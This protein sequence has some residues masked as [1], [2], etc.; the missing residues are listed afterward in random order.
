MNRIILALAIS[1]I[2]CTAT[3]QNFIDKI[4]SNVSM[5]IKYAGENFSRN[6]PLK[7]MDS[8]SFVKENLSKAFKIDSLT[9]LRDLGIDFE[10]DTYQFVSM[11]DSSMSFV[12]LFHLNNLPVFLKLVDANYHAE[13]KPEKMNGYE[14]LTLS[15]D[16]YLGW[17][18]S[19]AVLVVSKFQN[20]NR[21]NYYYSY[22][23]DTV[24]IADSTTT[25]IEDIQVDTVVMAP[26]EDYTIE[27]KE[28]APVEKT[29]TIK[30]KKNG[31]KKT[32]VNAKKITR[33]PAKKPVK[34]SKPKEIIDEEKIE[35]EEESTSTTV[36][37]GYQYND[38]SWQ[39]KR[40]AWD[41]TQDSIAK[42]RQKLV[43]SNIIERQFNGTVASIANDISYKKVIDAPAHVSM[44]INS[45]NFLR[46]YWSS[47]YRGFS[48]YGFSGAALAKDNKGDGFR[49]G[50]NLFFEKD[51][52]RIEQRS[53]S[54]DEKMANLGKD[55]FNNKQSASLLNFVNPGNIGYFSM[56]LNTEALANYYYKMFRQYLSNTPYM[57][58]YADL[59]DV[60]IDLLEIMID[61]KA[62]AELTPGNYMFVLHDMKTKMVSYTDYEYDDSFK[63]KEVKKT[64]PELSPNFTFVMETKREGFIQKVMDLPLKYAKKEKFNYQEK[65]G[66]YELVLDSG[67]YP[68]SSMY[69]MVKNGKAIV[70]TNKESIDMALTNKGYSPDGETRNSILN[71]N[72]SL[73][74]N[75]K[76]LLQQ[77]N[78]ELST[79]LN[80]KIS[81]YLEENI[82]DV[83][84]ESSLKDGMMQ[85]TTTMTITGNHTNSLEFFFN[86][87]DAINNI[88][89]KDKEQR[90]KKIN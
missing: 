63:Y 13:M 78:A 33:E 4:P 23:T 18:N 82:G 70:T 42:A 88:M 9:S 21:F 80:K 90:E 52:L 57:S 10:K 50:V 29:K 83:R 73:R 26:V 22:P 89:E 45:D 62:I 74:I 68:L 59:I 84:M 28:A 20:N 67:K 86:M 37:P 5:V 81:A 51:K 19:Q 55:L 66:Y 36:T 31:K 11:E 49:S 7:K 48:P 79:D 2:A 30:G 56:S 76:K 27:K 87:I 85:G 47:F 72:Y 64:K 39:A 65:G 16:T 15:A 40:D 8:Y 69:F 6:M 44:W 41:R 60:Y 25:V 77:L 61:E 14:F 58:E 38:S 32:T 3:A 1:I 75:S 12:S 46:Q 71:N 35:A 17:N 34:K 43:S 24:A 54:P 53:F